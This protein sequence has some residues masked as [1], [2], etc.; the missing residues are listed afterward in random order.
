MKQTGI[1]VE[2]ATPSITSPKISKGYAS[3]EVQDYV[4][5]EEVAPK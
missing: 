2:T 1:V 5:D 4:K 3:R